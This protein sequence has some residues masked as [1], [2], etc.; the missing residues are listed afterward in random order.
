MKLLKIM[1]HEF[2]QVLPPTLYFFVAFNVI[3]LTKA[4]MLKQHGIS[5]SGFATSF[6]RSVDR[7]ESHIDL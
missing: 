6:I 1:K 3:V 7:R 5:F 2:G 4:L